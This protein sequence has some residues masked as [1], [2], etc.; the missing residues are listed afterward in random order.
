[1]CV[2][3]R[4]QEHDTGKEGAFKIEMSLDWL[5]LLEMGNCW[6][7]IGRI[8]AWNMPMSVVFWGLWMPGVNA[9]VWMDD[10]SI[11]FDLDAPIG[12]FE[13]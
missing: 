11:L 8:Y 10:R 12:V 3:A 7:C 2:C 1:M 6:K 13:Y 9:L 4:E 5:V